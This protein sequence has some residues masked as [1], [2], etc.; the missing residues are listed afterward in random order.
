M[1]AEGTASIKSDIPDPLFAWIAVGMFLVT[2]VA[3]AFREVLGVKLGFIALTGAVILVLTV[4]ILG[5]RLKDAPT[6][7]T[8]CRNSTGARCSSTSRCSRWSAAWRR[9]TS[10][11]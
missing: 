6:S 3:M 2:V 1:S 9:P 10:W 8:S 4:E 5:E 7:S 11:R